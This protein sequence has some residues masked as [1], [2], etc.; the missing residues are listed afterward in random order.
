MKP[1]NGILNEEIEL[2][3]LTWNYHWNIEGPLF[4]SVH[5]MLEEQYTAL[6]GIIDEV[7]ERIRA[8]GGVAQTNVEAIFDKNVAATDMLKKLAAMHEGL[9]SKI[10]TQVAPEYE[11]K[12]DIGT[13]DLLTITSEKHD[14]MAWMLRATLK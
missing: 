9:S 12:G 13:V 14:K 11:E 4:P 5:K 1:L 3:L 7:A 2:Y 6:A 10:R 8:L